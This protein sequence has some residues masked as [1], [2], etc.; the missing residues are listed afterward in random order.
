MDILTHTLSGLAVGTVVAAF[1]KQGSIDKSKIILLSGVAGALPDLDTISLWSGFDSTIGRYFAL[2]ESGNSIYFAKYWYSHHAFMHS[3]AAAVFFAGLITMLLALLDCLCQQKAR[4]NRLVA[5]ISK[6]KLVFIGFLF[7]FITHLLEDMPTPASMWGGISLFWPAKT[8]IGGSGQLWWWNNYD[9]FLIV[10][11]AFVV[12]LLI[13]SV[14]RF[15]R[16]NAKVTAV[17]FMLATTLI[18]LQIKNRPYDFAYSGYTTKY[19]QFEATSKAL[20]KDILGDR[21][22]MWMEKF[23]NRLKIYF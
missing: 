9:I 2:N 12:N 22:F 8:Y 17:I 4:F 5:S 23:D 11:A 1:S 7:G 10:L 20:Q 21:L 3:L 18:L 15:L 19:Q 16:I 13:L 6:Q 14:G